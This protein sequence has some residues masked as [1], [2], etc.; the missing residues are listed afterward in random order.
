MPSGKACAGAAH[1]QE[2]PRQRLDA[3]PQAMPEPLGEGQR[4]A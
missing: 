3:L 4:A 1:R 2:A